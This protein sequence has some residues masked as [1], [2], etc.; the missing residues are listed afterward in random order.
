MGNCSINDFFNQKCIINPNNNIKDIIFIL[1]NLKNEL[2]SGLMNS[3]LNNAIENK[4]NLIFK[5]NNIA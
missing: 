3:L 2:K 5:Y 1:S 4:D